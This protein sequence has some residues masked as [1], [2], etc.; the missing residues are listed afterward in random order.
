MDNAFIF[1]VKYVSKFH[2]TTVVFCLDSPAGLSILKEQMLAA[3]VK[4]A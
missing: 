3:R 4:K 2:P 1:S